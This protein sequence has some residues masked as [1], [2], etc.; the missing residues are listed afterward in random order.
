MESEKQ[1]VR[2]EKDVR[3]E[4][5][6]A[7]IPEGR[8][9]LVHFAVGCADGTNAAYVGR[10]ATYE[11]VVSRL[12]TSPAELPDREFNRQ[13]FRNHLIAKGYDENGHTFWV[14]VKRPGDS[15]GAAWK[16]TTT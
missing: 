6:I 16:S 7:M 13:I 5:I 8:P 15:L 4:Q 2:S 14:S 3:P 12:A 10:Q 1:E 9:L 11:D